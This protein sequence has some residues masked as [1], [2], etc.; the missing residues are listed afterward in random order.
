MTEQ[1]DAQAEFALDRRRVLQATAM[2]GG[3]LLIPGALRPVAAGA[4][5]AA[6]AESQV[7]AW[8]RIAADN[9]VTLIASQSEMG[10][11]TTTTL[12]AAV[13]TELG[14]EVGKIGIAFSPLA[15]PYRDPVYHWMFTGNSQSIS[16]FYPMMRQAGAAAREMLLAAAA[17]RLN[18]PADELSTENGVIRHAKSNRSLTFGQVAADAAKLPV[19]ENPTLR[20]DASIGQSVARWDIPAKV[21][22]SAVFGIDVTLPGMLVAAVRCA[23]RFGATIATYDAAAIKAKTGVVAVVE[24]PHG[25]A[26]VAKTYWQARSALDPAEIIWSDAGSRFT[27]GAQLAPIYAEKLAA[28]PFFSH[29]AA[30]TREDGATRIE[31]TYEVPFQAHAT[32]EPMNCTARVTDGTCEIWAPTQGVEMTQNVA[33]QVT[34]LPLD[35]IVIHRT[36]IGGGFGRRLLADFVKQALIVAMAVKQPVKLIWSREEDMTHDFYRPG[37]LHHV[38]GSIGKS[39]D[40]VSLAHRLVS[41]SH[42]LYIIPRGMLPPMQDWTDP[43]APPEKVDTMG[44]EGLIE[45]PYDIPNQNVEQHRLEIDVPVSVWRTTGH[46]PN[47]FVLE[48]FIDEL[49]AAAGVEPPTFRRTL[50]AKNPRVLKVYDLAWQKAILGGSSMADQLTRPRPMPLFRGSAIASAFGGVIANVV[51]LTVADDKIKIHR[52][53]AAVDCGRTLDPKIAESNILGG[54]VWGLSAMRTE[55]TF[56]NGAATQSNFDVFEPLHLW[57][58]PQCEVYFVDSGERLGGTGELGPVPV[59]AAV[60]NAIFVATGKRVRALPLSKSGL[61]FA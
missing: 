28:G 46:G 7:G 39:R 32:M 1:A 23:P 15:D 60:C 12:A 13:A 36:L 4:G 10:Q 9:S 48:S 29:K 55:I 17:A 18:V 53:I 3:I 5:E 51:E 49:A 42:M 19:P 22:G 16:S 57:E 14:V 26:V 11:G 52:V 37:M 27:S 8:V 24:V 31:A 50:L 38:A 33:A 25:L 61:S 59:Q 41:P 35:K 45:I 21:D 40:A 58:T 43:A 6:S 54:I 56:E 34:G 2:V 20:A 30:K 44:V 47:N